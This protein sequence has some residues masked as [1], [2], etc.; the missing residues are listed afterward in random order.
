[1]R[2][3]VYS[4][5]LG[6]SRSWRKA[7]VQSLAQALLIHERIQT[8]LARA[9]EAQRLAERLITLGKSGSLSA[10]RRAV[11]L[12]RDPEVVDR[13]FRDVAP[14]FAHRAGGYTR[15]FHGGYRPGDGASL[16][17]LELVEL[18]KTLEMLPKKKAQK[19]KEPKKL[20]PKEEPQA[21]KTEPEKTSQKPKKEKE[22]EKPKGF[23]EGLR[24]F[25]KGRNKQQ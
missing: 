24:D 9:K 20:A 11:S 19:E 25:F 18:H 4:R 17:V 14:R 8:T 15:I 1:M 12:L 22:P 3:A 10:R 7:T 6:R 21:P 5:D 2:H 16:A 13:L 23:F